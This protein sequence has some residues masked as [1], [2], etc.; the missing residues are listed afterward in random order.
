MASKHAVP[1]SKETQRISITKINWL[2]RFGEKITVYSENHI[3]L[4]NT[5]VGKIQLLLKRVIY[6]HI[7]HCTLKRKD[8]CNLMGYQRWDENLTAFLVGLLYVS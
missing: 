2:M 5:S 3:K 6:V 1:T 8:S 7:K 4:I